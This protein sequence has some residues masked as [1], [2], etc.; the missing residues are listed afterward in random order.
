MFETTH[1]TREVVRLRWRAF[2]EAG[3]ATRSSTFAAYVAA[4]DAEEAEG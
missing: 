1:T 4:L 2:L 3:R